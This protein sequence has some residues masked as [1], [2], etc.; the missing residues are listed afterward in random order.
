YDRQTDDVGTAPG[1]LTLSAAKLHASGMN[2]RLGR[3]D[4]SRPFLS[5]LKLLDRSR[6]TIRFSEPMDTSTRGVLVTI[7]DT[8]KG[9]PLGIRD[10]SF[11]EQASSE[12]QVA[13][14]EQDSTVVYRL[15]VTGVKDRAGNVIREGTNAEVFRGAP[16]ADTLRPLIGLEN[17]PDS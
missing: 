3:E 12:G 17:I 9:T 2:F 14:D 1:D 4:T 16:H 6:L 7:V 10:I 13:T 15:K 5:G 8:L 11:A